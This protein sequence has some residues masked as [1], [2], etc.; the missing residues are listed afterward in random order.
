MADQSSNGTVRVLEIVFAS[1]ALFGAAFAVTRAALE[2]RLPY[3][4][5][6]AVPNPWTYRPP[7]KGYTAPGYAPRVGGWPK[8]EIK[9]KEMPN[10]FD[11]VEL[12]YTPGDR[13][14][15]RSVASYRNKNEALYQAGLKLH[16][17]ARNNPR[18]TNVHR[19]L[20]EKGR[21]AY[22]IRAF[23]GEPGYVELEC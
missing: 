17:Y 19:V 14:V 16:A 11:L 2:R 22:A 3:T 21:C 12:E 9:L 13:P 1:A 23:E 5:P 4:P 10:G 15:P 20:D 18:N 8:Y 6:G 7:I